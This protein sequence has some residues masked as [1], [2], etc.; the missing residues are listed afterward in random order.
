MPGDCAS[1]T[2]FNTL[3]LADRCMIEPLK[4]DPCNSTLFRACVRITPTPVEGM[5]FG[6]SPKE[7]GSTTEFV[8]DNYER[9]VG[10][11]FDQIIGSL[12][13]DD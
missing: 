9:T 1:K 10:F 8:L 3:D 5:D 7:I 2:H 6:T 4:E 12:T 11:I 13:S